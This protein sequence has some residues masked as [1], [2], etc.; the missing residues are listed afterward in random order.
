LS[1]QDNTIINPELQNVFERVRQ[2]A[3]FMPIWQVKVSN[4]NQEKKIIIDIY[5]LFLESIN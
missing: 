5:S 2:S 3:D 1:I 4:T